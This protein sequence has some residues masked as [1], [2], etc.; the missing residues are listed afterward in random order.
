[1][2]TDND[3]PLREQIVEILNNKSIVKSDVFDQCFEVFNILKEVLSG[4]SNDISELLDE[5]CDRRVRLEYRDR[6][7]FE[8]ELKFADDVLIFS[9]NTDVYVFDR[10]HPIWKEN[11]VKENPYN[12]YCGVIS[13]YNFLSDSLKY[14]RPDDLGYLV[15]RLFINKDKIFFVEGKRQE[16]QNTSMFGQYK[17][18]KES[19]VSIVEAAIK[20]SLTFDLLVPP[21]DLVKEMSVGMINNKIESSKMRVGKRIGYGY[22]SDDVLNSDK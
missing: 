7:K 16:K 4:I 21:F 5:T 17:M 1:M 18:S 6:G 10:N 11:F 2:K 12:A 20:Y 19:L 15:A 13:V 8:A 9:M 3:V 22:N 14:N